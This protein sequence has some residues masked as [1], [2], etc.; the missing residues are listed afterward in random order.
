MKPYNKDFLLKE[1][2]KY[3]NLICE[4]QCGNYSIV[5]SNIEKVK[6]QGYMY[7]EK[8]YCNTNIIELKE[9]DKSIMKLDLREIQGDY[10]AIKSAKG[11]VGIVGLGLG[12]TAQ[13]FAAK[14]DVEEVIV[15]EINSEII[16]MYNENFKHNEKIKIIHGDVFKAEKQKFDFFFVDI[17]NYKLTSKV[18]TDYKKFNKLHEIEEYSFWGM[19]H[20][21]LSCNYEELLWIYIPENWVSMCK[22]IYEKLQSSG[23]IEYYKPLSEKK[24]SVILQKFKEVLNAEE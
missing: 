13:E 20:F 10:A 16:D 1:L 21:L 15:Y 3:N 5:K 14:K 2:D 6:M 7:K 9:K 11:K 23:Y 19:E 17:Y 22:M 4:R 18:V 12:Y 24:V 8:E